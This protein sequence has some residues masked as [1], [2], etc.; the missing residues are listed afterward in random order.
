MLFHFSEDASITSFLPHVP[1]SSPLAGAAVWAI[2]EE[3]S[4]A[5]WFPRECPRVTVWA[6][7]DD[8]L[9]ALQSAFGTTARRVHVIE[10]AW[11]ER[12]QRCRLHRYTFDP[13]PF[14]PWPE[15]EGQWTTTQTVTPLN[16]TPVGNLLERHQSAK[17]DLR[18]VTDLA[19]WKNLATAGP[20]DFS[21]IRY[22]NARTSPAE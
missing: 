4:P 3:H 16:V 19:P 15:A 2:D 7:D 11:E 14:T 17:I 6:R 10:A 9:L 13:T 22:A 21:I 20:W 12:M 5:Y 8:E 18:F 1:R